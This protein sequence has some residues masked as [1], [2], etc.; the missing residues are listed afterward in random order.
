MDDATKHRTGLLI[1]T[2][3][4][5]K[6]EVLILTQVLKDNFDL[7]CSLW[8]RGGI[9]YRIYVQAHS[10]DN[11]RSLVRPYFVPSMMYKLS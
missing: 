10:M 3:A 2:E 4:Y 11:L 7:D 8:K 6:E 1:C 5:S 9:G